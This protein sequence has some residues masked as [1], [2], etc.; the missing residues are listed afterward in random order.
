MNELLDRLDKATQVHAII[1]TCSVC[2]HRGSDVH[3]LPTYSCTLKRDTTDYFCDDIGACLDRV[4]GEE[5]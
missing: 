1:R 3:E 4:A 2:K 5:S